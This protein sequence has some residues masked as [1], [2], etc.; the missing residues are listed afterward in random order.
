MGKKSLVQKVFSRRKVGTL[1]RAG[2][3]SVLI[4]R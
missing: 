3:T 1:I 4:L 2:E